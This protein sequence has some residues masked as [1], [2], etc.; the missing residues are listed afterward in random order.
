MQII[1]GPLLRIGRFVA[2]GARQ[3]GHVGIVQAFGQAQLPACDAESGMLASCL[4]AL[5][6]QA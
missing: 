3:V 4:A 6:V 1:K 2:Q 5:I